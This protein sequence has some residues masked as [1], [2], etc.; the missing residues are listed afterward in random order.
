M[1]QDGSY[2]ERTGEWEADDASV[3]GHEEKACCVRMV[4]TLRAGLV[5]RRGLVQRVATPVGCRGR[6]GADVGEAGGYR[7]RRHAGCE[8]EAVGRRSLSKRFGS[9]AANETPLLFGASSPPLP[10][11]VA[12]IDANKYDLVDGRRLGVELICRQLQ[13][14]P[15]S[16]YAAKT[17][18]PSARAV[19]DGELVELWET[20]P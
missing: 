18:V 11:V 9:C 2:A 8:A 17:R 19:R 15:S 13:V 10:E 4:R 12:F 20:R 1:E 7:R 6:V 16:Y 5:S 14:A 3:L